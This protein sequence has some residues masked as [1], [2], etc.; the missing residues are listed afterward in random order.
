MR[1]SFCRAIAHLEIAK[2]H[3]P[4]QSADD[5]GDDNKVPL[6]SHLLK[7]KIDVFLTIQNDDCCLSAISSDEVTLSIA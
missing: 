2:A 3:C 4:Q 1:E 7:R 6:R 5:D